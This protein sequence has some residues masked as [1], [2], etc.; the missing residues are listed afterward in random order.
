MNENLAQ[1]PAIDSQQFQ[2]LFQQAL[3]Q[4]LRSLP[5][6]KVPSWLEAVIEYVKIH[7]FE[8]LFILFI[9]SLLIS[10][11]I[12]EVLC[13]YLKTNEILSRLNKLEKRLDETTVKRP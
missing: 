12:R 10:A 6:P 5:R 2:N 13:S 7:P 9:A 4:T 1:N 3:S 11:L 8:A